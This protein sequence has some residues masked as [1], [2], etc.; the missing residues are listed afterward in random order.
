MRGRK[1]KPVQL[2]LIEGTFRPDRHDDNRAEPSGTAPACPPF[3]RGT[4][5]KEWFRIVPALERLGI[6]DEVDQATLACYCQ[7][8]SDYSWAVYK[9]RREGR[10]VTTP[11]GIRRP[12]AA[13]KIQRE[14]ALLLAKFAEQFGLSPVARGRLQ[15]EPSDDVDPEEAEYFD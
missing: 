12:H 11:S 7:A 10:I 5:R 13:M 4:A 15:V 1:R 8:R 2:H 9:V 6:L 3:L 14:A